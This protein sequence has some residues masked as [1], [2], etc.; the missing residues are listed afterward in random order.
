MLEDDVDTLNKTDI[1]LRKKTETLRGLSVIM[2][3]HQKYCNKIILIS[4]I[5]KNSIYQ[6]TIVQMNTT[7][8]QTKAF[9][10]TVGK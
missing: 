7:F 5:V 1:T 6:N 9:F 3:E 4:N 8:A 2:R 10:L